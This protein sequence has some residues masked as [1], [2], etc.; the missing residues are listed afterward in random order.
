MLNGTYYFYSAVSW[1]QTETELIA[2]YQ[3]KDMWYLVVLALC[4]CGVKFCSGDCPA[5]GPVPAALNTIVCPSLCMNHPCIEQEDP[6]C[7]DSQSKPNGCN[8]CDYNY[9]KKSYNHPCVHCQATFGTECLFCQDFNGCGQ[10]SSHCQRVYDYSCSLWKCHCSTPSPTSDTERIEIG[11]TSFTGI[12]DSSIIDK[13]EEDDPP[14]EDETIITVDDIFEESQILEVF[15]DGRQYLTFHSA[16]YLQEYVDISNNPFH[17]S[18]SGVNDDDVDV[19]PTE[20][21]GS[22]QSECEVRLMMNLT[23][24]LTIVD[25]VA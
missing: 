11:P 2:S 13:N 8:Q 19:D 21:D 15:P 5:S 7:A 1:L 20:E 22:L 24:N 18:T 14:I 25:D 17:P 6:C 3:F 12:Y 23:V 9:F 4:V 10:C 16:S